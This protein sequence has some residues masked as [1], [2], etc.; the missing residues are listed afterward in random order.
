MK[1]T[2]PG[3]ILLLHAV[4][5]DNAEVLGR[6]LDDLKSDGYVFKSLENLVK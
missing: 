3:C 2:F 5:K 4:S 6:V 1:G